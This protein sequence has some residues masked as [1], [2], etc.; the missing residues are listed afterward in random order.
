MVENSSGLDEDDVPP[1]DITK[2][3]ERLMLPQELMRSFF[4]DFRDMYASIVNDIGKLISDGQ[5][6]EAEELV[7]S[8]K[9][10]T[11]TLGIMPVY[12]AVEALELAILDGRENDT[13]VC[14]DLLDKQMVSF[15]AEVKN[16][17]D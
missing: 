14:L 6:A 2:A 9:G 1:F 5:T 13:T 17:L 7:H 12:K 11:G 3:H 4:S 10:V 16:Y 15:L 8:L